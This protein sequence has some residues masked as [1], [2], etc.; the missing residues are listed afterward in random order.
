MKPIPI[1]GEGV[2]SYSD[3]VT[4]QR[5][6]NCLYDIRKDGDRTAVIVVGTPGSYVWTTIPS[7]PIYGWCVAGNLLYVVASTSLYSVSPG[8]V[9]T[10]L[11]TLPTVSS[12]VSMDTNSVDVLIVDGVTGY[13]Y[14]IASGTLTTVTDVNFPAGTISIAELNS[15]YYAVRPNSREF[16]ASQLLDGTTWSPQVFGTKENTSDEL[17]QVLNFS[18]VLALFGARSIEFWQDTGASPLPVTRITGATQ[19]WGLAAIRS[20]SRVGNT[21]MFLGLDPDGG[22]RV[23][24]LQGY[25]PIPVSTSDI[26]EIINKMT[27][28]SDAT[29]ITYNSFG[30]SLYQITFPS[31]DRSFLFDNSTGMWQETQTGLDVQTRHFADLGISFARRNVVTD[32]SSGSLYF[33][34]DEHFTDNGTSIKREVCTRHIYADGNEQFLA[35]F[36]LA[37]EVGVSNGSSIMLEVSRDGGK[38]FGPQKIKSLG[39]LGDY[40]RPIVFNRL[41]RARDFVLRISMTDQTRFIIT[42]ASATL[43]VANG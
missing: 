9:Y 20:I 31:E 2:R 12:K 30:H 29:A 34:D 39:A 35:Q 1:F 4:R 38:T 28:I 24:K 10:L 15:R 37:M 23:V 6:L 43:E 13:V 22:V 16:D 27:V 19:Q 33:L 42:N 11:G 17:L 26:N 7:S 40:L 25:T 18:G 36:M 32:T 3:V 21:L 41:G 14:N 5:R 8:G